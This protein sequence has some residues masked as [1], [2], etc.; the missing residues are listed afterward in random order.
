MESQIICKNLKSMRISLAPFSTRVFQYDMPLIFRGRYDIGVKSVR[1]H[2][3][4]GLFSWSL[5]SFERKSILVKPRII[6]IPYKDIAE[7]RISEADFNSGLSES[8]NDDVLNIRNYVYGDSFRK[9]HWKLTSKFS[10]TMVK[11]TRNQLDNDVLIIL[12]LQ[13][14]GDINEATLIKEDCLIEELISHINY[15]LQKNIP[16]KLC[17]NIA[18]R[19]TILRA[20]TPV[21]FNNIYQ[22]LSEVKFKKTGDFNQL[23]DYFT[24]TEMTNNLVYIFS[25]TLD[26]DTISKAFSI[27][28]KGFDLEL[29]HIDLEGVD[30]ND[31][32]ASQELADML[33]KSNIR[34]YKLEPSVIQLEGSQKEVI[35][36][37]G[38]VEVRAYEA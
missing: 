2:D 38:N 10:K 26:G 21:D 13:N 35:R 28:N 30:E 5:R 3:L 34:S 29:Y 33:M 12:N 6:D 18:D 25:T 7:A 1:I 32:K 14:N 16:V 9:I 15:L 19:P 23:L 24:D 4:M 37:K 22:F 36:S 17:F 11:E 27:R 20:I 8:G 31:T